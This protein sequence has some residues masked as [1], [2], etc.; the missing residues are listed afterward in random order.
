LANGLHFVDNGNGTAT[1]SGTPAP[2]TGAAY[3]VTVT[4]TNGLGSAS[5]TFTLKIDE[6]PTITSPATATATVGTSFFLQTSASGYP[7]PKMTKTGTLPK[8]LAFSG[9]AITGT[10][11]AGSAGT[12]AITITAKNAAGTTTQLL[13]LTVN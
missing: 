13:T 12:Y 5:E 6:A 3:Q 11:K 1:L 2:G 7:A 9:G 4:A 10:P 8:G